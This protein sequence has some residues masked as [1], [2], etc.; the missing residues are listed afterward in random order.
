MSERIGRPEDWFD[1][2]AH[3][4]RGAEALYAAARRAV[5]ENA[6]ANAAGAAW[7]AFRRALHAAWREGRREAMRRQQ[8]ADGRRVSGQ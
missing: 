6:P 2:R 1:K 4:L 7:Q 5:G 8:A 3:A